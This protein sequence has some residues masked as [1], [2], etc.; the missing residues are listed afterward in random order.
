M[1]IVTRL[2]TLTTESITDIPMPGTSLTP[3]SGRFLV[4]LSAGF[5]GDTQD[6]DDTATVSI[7]VNG[8]QVPGSEREVWVKKGRDGSVTTVAVVTGLLDG[9]TIEGQWR[10]EREKNMTLKQRTLIVTRYD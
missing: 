10:T 4:W 2:D 1:S 9:Q 7:Y 6:G 8:V 3:G 5:E